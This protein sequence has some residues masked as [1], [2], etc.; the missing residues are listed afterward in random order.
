[1]ISSTTLFL[2][3][4][5]LNVV[6]V[7]GAPI[8]IPAEIAPRSLDNS[9]ASVRFAR[10]EIFPSPV[11]ALVT[12]AIA[13][14]FTVV[15]RD[16]EDTVRRYP[17]RFIHEYLEKRGTTVT[18]KIVVSEKVIKHDTPA[19]T[20]AF[21]QS[22]NGAA[23]N[24]GAGGLTTTIGFTAT[25]TVPGA[26]TPT[27]VTTTVTA[28]VTPTVTGTP[29]GNT[30]A[31]PGGATPPA[32]GT[33]GAT[34]PANPPTTDT[35]KP[36]DGT[37]T[38]GDNTN[39][40]TPPAAPPAGTDPNTTTTTPGATSGDD[41]KAKPADGT[42]TTPPAATTTTAG[43]TDPATGAG[44]GA[45][46][47]TK[48]ADGTTTTT[49]GNTTPT[50]NTTTPPDNTTAATRREVKAEASAQPIAKRQIASSGAA[51]AS[52]LRRRAL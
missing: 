47:N 37:T 36:A 17:R 52:S 2:A 13:D 41:T 25:I 29:A 44:A 24:G 33:T 35:T 28:T 32:D 48:P 39:A 16:A 4:L 42:T 18:E 15:K 22:H 20:V 1:M 43:A 45:D 40:T 8:S 9:G 46:G 21:G 19:D 11:P 23:A 27:T 7:L 10:E 38:P 3:T 12:R 26:P 50:D 51:F 31:T 14:A 34:T 6:A 49:D 30:G 5:A